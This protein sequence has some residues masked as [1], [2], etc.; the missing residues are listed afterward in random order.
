MFGKEG[1]GTRAAERHKRAQKKTHSC[2]EKKMAGKR[3]K[4]KDNNAAAF[5]SWSSGPSGS[6]ATCYQVDRCYLRFPHGQC[7]RTDEERLAEP[8]HLAG[9]LSGASAH[10]LAT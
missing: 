7:R 10:A 1:A 4:E 8:T 6:G 9:A 3:R 2:S 5:R